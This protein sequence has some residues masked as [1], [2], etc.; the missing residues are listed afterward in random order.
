MK[1]RNLFVVI[2]GISLVAAG[3]FK[4]PVAP[5]LPS[6]QTPLTFPLL[7]RL[8]S[9]V[10]LQNDS[11]ITVTDT[12]LGHLAFVFSDTMESVSITSQ[13]LSF[14][15]GPPINIPPINVDN[16]ELGV[17]QSLAPIDRTPSQLQNY[18]AGDTILFFPATN[19]IDAADTIDIPLPDNIPFFKSVSR[20]S[21]EQGQIT[22]TVDNQT[23]LPLDTVLIR[24][25]TLD[26]A[27]IGETLDSMQAYSVKDIV[28]DLSGKELTPQMRLYT[29]LTNEAI[30][31]EVLQSSPAITLQPTVDIANIK[32]VTG[33]TKDTTYTDTMSYGFSN[34]QVRLRRG[35]F[36]DYRG[37]PA[38]GDSNALALRN[39][40][41]YIPA[42]LTLEFEFMNI[43]KP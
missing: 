37:T 1:L 16:T 14:A 42:D 29:Y 39:W 25:S 3:C 4:Q 36:R 13:D 8:Y 22:F 31:N 6:W 23:P 19:I 43:Y 33:V 12:S 41:N 24:L 40:L 9:L 15:S 30:S 7:D 35:V 5:K 18:Q 10:D 26:G 17:T 2:L 34:P 28:L 11:T 38:E 32:T 21:V 27:L 20:Y